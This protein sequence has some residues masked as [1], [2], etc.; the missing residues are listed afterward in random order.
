MSTKRIAALTAALTTTAAAHAEA[1]TALETQVNEGNLDLK[2]KMQKEQCHAKVN[3]D[4]VSQSPEVLSVMSQFKLSGEFIDAQSREFK[5]RFKKICVGLTTNAR[6]KDNA[7]DAAFCYL[8]AKQE[9]GV[10]EFTFQ[11]I[12]REMHHE[13]ATQARNLRLLLVGLGAAEKVKGGFTVN[14]E[15]PALAR[16]LS[17]Y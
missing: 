5:L 10:T 11:Q 13:T 2:R 12:Q 17:V 16:I 6:P 4:L 8:K 3:A 7:A 9:E 1:A 14:Y 15:A